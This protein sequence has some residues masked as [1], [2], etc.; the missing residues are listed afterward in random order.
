M[1]QQQAGHSHLQLTSSMINSSHI[2]STDLR[3]GS[4][5][6]LQEFA[7]AAAAGQA[8]TGGLIAAQAKLSQT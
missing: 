3:V 7:S 2:T 6:L 5:H 1:T 8:S 4:W